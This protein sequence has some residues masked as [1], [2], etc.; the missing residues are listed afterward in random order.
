MR[1]YIENWLKNALIKIAESIQKKIVET[2]EEV[3]LKEST[4][5][6]LARK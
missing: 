1:E 4:K 3:S 2:G 6:I 5:D